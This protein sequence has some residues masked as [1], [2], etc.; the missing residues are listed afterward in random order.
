MSKKSSNFVVEIKNQTIMKAKNTLGQQVTI[1]DKELIWNALY[2]LE[3][4]HEDT[5]NIFIAREGNK[6]GVKIPE[7]ELSKLCANLRKSIL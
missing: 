6:A 7:S 1:S 5:G 3:M 2:Y 4:R